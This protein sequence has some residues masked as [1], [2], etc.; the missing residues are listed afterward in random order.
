MPEVTDAR[1]P[2]T[3]QCC[4]LS[5]KV[6]HHSGQTPLTAALLPCRTDYY[7]PPHARRVVAG[8][9]D[10]AHNLL[11]CPEGRAV[12]KLN[13][14]NFRLAANMFTLLRPGDDY[15]C[16]PDPSRLWSCYAIRFMGAAAPHYF[17]ALTDNGT[18]ICRQVGSGLR[19]IISFGRLAES[20]AAGSSP[21]MLL[22]A[23]A[24][25]HMLLADLHEECCHFETRLEPV[26]ERVARLARTIADNPSLQY[27]IPELSGSAGLSASRFTQQ[28]RR[29]TG[30]GPLHYVM[31]HRIELAKQHLREN[32]SKIQT[33]ARLVGWDD[34]YYFSRVFKRYT[35]TTPQEFRLR[36]ARPAAWA[37]WARLEK[38]DAARHP[39]D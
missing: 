39:A 6:I 20:L 9:D 5:A 11:F 1:E 2:D 24:A 27:S 13:Q 32:P 4:A 3:A 38:T 22:R 28:F 16:L 15:R 29:R 26:E 25:M 35:G 31:M 19:F 10:Q 36:N 30:C 23:A 34:V 18:R 12:L 14:R 17:D 33:I 7:A 8:C 21:A 37:R